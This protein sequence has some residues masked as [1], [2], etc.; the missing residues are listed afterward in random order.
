MKDNKYRSIAKGSAIFGGTQIYNILIGIIRGKLV[1]MILGPEGMGISSLLNSASSTIQQFSSFGINLSIVREIA[2]KKDDE[3]RISLIMYTARKLLKFTGLIG[4]LFAILFCTYLSKITFGSTEYK[5]HFVFLSI[6]IFFTTLSN[7]ETSI[8]Q[9]F[10]ALKKL[11]FSSIIGS[12]TGLLVGVPLYY[13]FGYNGIVPAMIILSLVTYTFY[14]YNTQKLINYHE[15]K[16][17]WEEIKPLAK[18]ILSLGIIMM[19][20]SLLGSLCNFILNS[21]IR[22]YG[23]LLDVGY[24][25]AANTITNQYIGIVFTAMSLDYFPRLSAISSDNNKVR[26]LV[27]TQSELVILAITPLAIALILFAPL[28]VK[29][30]LTDDFISVIPLIRFFGLGIIFKAISYPLGYISF[31]KGDKKFFFYMEGVLGNILT[32]SFNCISFYFYG[33]LGLGISFILSYFAYFVIIKILTGKK[34]KFQYNRK[35]IPIITVSILLPSLALVASYI[36]NI[37]FSN[38]IMGII[39]IISITYSIYELNKRLSLFKK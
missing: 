20:A 18:T 28:I 17:K 35:I 39:L 10:Q 11:A 23:G 30:L 7:G 15:H 5:W 33:I 26:K 32:L 1:A 22:K 4:A 13:I 24:F 38:V 6:M 8:L 37:L 14:R 27:N 34:Y 3:D 16:Y 19:T 12:T 25:Q 2:E 31:S 29:I 21:F 9:G 36:N